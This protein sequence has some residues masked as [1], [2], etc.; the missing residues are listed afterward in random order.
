[1]FSIFCLQFLLIKCLS[2]FLFGKIYFFNIYLSYFNLIINFFFFFFQFRSWIHGN[3]NQFCPKC[4]APIK[5]ESQKSS[6]DEEIREDNSDTVEKKEEESKAEDIQASVEMI[7]REREHRDIMK[8][9]NEIELLQSITSYDNMLKKKDNLI[10]EDFDYE[11]I[12]ELEKEIKDSVFN[13]DL[14]N[15]ISSNYA[16]CTFYLFFDYLIIN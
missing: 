15:N 7:L 8:A 16:K 6:F 3:I 11:D 9:L 12:E 2:T 4:K 10:K 5:I 1:M 13:F 14:Q